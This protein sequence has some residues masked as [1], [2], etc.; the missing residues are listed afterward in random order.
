M[1]RY[2]YLSLVL[3]AAL[4]AC[5][6]KGETIPEVPDYA[7]ITQWYIAD[8]HHRSAA[9]ALVGQEKKEQNP[10]HTG[11]EEYNYFMTVIFPDNQ[12]N[13]IDYN[14]VV[15]DHNGLTKEQFIVAVG[16]NYDLQDMGTEIYKPAKLQLGRPVAAAGALCRLSQR[17]PGRSWSASQDGPTRQYP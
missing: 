13:V 8:G 3:A 10:H 7:D 4:A 14:R 17:H 16:E 5:S 2:L 6:P 15:K 12:L 11:K 9:A 1:K